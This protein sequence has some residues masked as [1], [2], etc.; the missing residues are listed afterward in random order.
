MKHRS[1]LLLVTALVFC[2][3][4]ISFSIYIP[5][6]VAQGNLATVHKPF[7]DF[8]LPSID[9]GEVSMSDFIGKKNVVLVTFRG[10]MGFW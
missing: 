2:I 9:G 6:T 8:T 5:D 7:A 3:T 1:N 10:W 4:L